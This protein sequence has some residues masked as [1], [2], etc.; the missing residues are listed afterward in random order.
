MIINGDEIVSNY[1]GQQVGISTDDVNTV[2]GAGSHDF[3]TLCTH[4]NINKWS[5]FKPGYFLVIDGILT[6]R[7]PRLG[8]NIDPRGADGDRPNF[9]NAYITD[10]DGY[11]HSAPAMAIQGHS[12][13]E[14]EV[15]SD[16]NIATITEQISLFLSNVDWFGDE[17]IY[18][19]KN[20]IS[21]NLQVIF[22]KSDTVNGTYVT[23]L[24]IDKENITQNTANGE[25]LI[26]VP[27]TGGQSKKTFVKFGL[28]HGNNISSYFDALILECTVYKRLPPTWAFNMPSSSLQALFNN[29]SGLTSAD[30][31]S[32]IYYCYFS[33]NSGD[34]TAGST[35][36]NIN[37]SAVIEMET[38][39]RYKVVQSRW[40][41]GGEIYYSKDGV[42][43]N[44]TS[45]SKTLAVNSLYEY[46]LN[47]NLT[48]TAA[49]EEQH[50]I[51]FL[52][53]GR[54]AVELI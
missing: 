40:T 23:A 24:A 14:I 26:S 47:I 19:G 25:I 33:P 12:V 28:G 51:K 1:N 50:I 37:F 22:V 53:F 17:T 49:D 5:R 35:I 15:A 21:N 31:S 54:T 43:Y 32:Q 42:Q 4:N 18:N 41:V 30:Q 8:D 45:F 27:A 2:L 48:K 52:S 3:G 7:K 34:L 10:F 29:L 16:Y 11:K 44:T 46:N 13:R 20:Y 9:E 6:Y 38:G 39:N 36:A